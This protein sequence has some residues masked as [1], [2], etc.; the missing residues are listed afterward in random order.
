MQITQITKINLGNILQWVDLGLVLFLAPI[1]GDIFFPSEHPELSKLAAF[2]VFAG[3]FLCRPIGGIIFGHFG[4]KSGRTKPLRFAILIINLST[5]FIGA[6]PSY[7]SFGLIGPILFTLLCSIQGIAIG[8]AYCGVMTYLV[9]SAPLKIRGFIGSFASMGATLGFLLA[10]ITVLFLQ[11]FFDNYAIETWAWRLPFLL[12]G[13]IGT[14]ITY[15]HL[16]LVETPVFE[17]LKREKKIEPQPLIK[18]LRKE[19]KSLLIIFCLSAMS[20]GFFYVFFGYMPEYLQNYTNV[21]SVYAFSVQLCSLLGLLILSPIMGRLGDYFG[22]KNILLIT[23]S[24]MVV[25]AFP[26]F[27]LL[28]LNSGFFIILTF[29][30]ATLF[31]SM[32]Q[33]NVLT[34]MVESSTGNIRYSSIAFAFNLSAAVFGGLSPVI[35]ITLIDKINL[36]APG[37]YIIFSALLGLIAVSFVP[38]GVSEKPIL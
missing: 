22:R 37:Y 23:T 16:K 2:G 4:D 12:I 11:I 13:L 30:L 6:L 33:G 14:Y 21:S 38:K 5:I 9:E 24:C 7:E 1:I 25:F 17:K 36:L 32:V 31:S 26:L 34:T 20:N 8:G 35:V 28:Q 18:A 19:P 29:A 15:F 27:Y 10:T 3:S